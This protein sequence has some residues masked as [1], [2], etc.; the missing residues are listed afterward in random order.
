[1]NRRKSI[2]ALLG[3]LIAAPFGVVAAKAIAAAGAANPASL[4]NSDS[5]CRNSPYSCH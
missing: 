4:G 3:A 1:M 2:K 5:R